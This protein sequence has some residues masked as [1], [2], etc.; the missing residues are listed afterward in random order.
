MKKYLL[1]TTAAGAAL[2]MAAPAN[3]GSYVSI[4]GGYSMSDQEASARIGQASGTFG[5]TS[6]TTGSTDTL[7]THGHIVSYVT[8]GTMPIVT[9]ATGFG[10]THSK[11]S[12]YR[13][14]TYTNGSWKSA[15][16]V[17]F[18]ADSGFVVGAA[19]GKD[20]ATGLRGEIEFS[21]RKND[22][23]VDGTNYFSSEFSGVWYA[24]KYSYERF[25]VTEATVSATISGSAVSNT[26]YFGT[27]P[28]Y[29]PTI[30][31]NPITEAGGT[32][33]GGSYT[34]T[35]VSASGDLSAM[36]IMANVWLDV[37][38]NLGSVHPY[39]GAGIGYAD[40][41]LDVGGVETGDTAVAFQVA[42]GFGWDLPN[43]GH[44]INLEVRRFVV[45]K[46]ELRLDS[47][48][49]PLDY[50]TTDIIVAYRIN[51]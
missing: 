47:W 17:D 51:F 40:V 19:F 27:R 37:D 22:V 23:S 31:E 34:K 2:A 42:A 14:M 41:T 12:F 8:K 44:R 39:V 36:S 7:W 49:I 6:T 45:P 43:S 30:S 50:E 15:T 33:G 11:V 25:H 32:E 1:T 20:I 35:D 9:E 18:E 26:H 38:M 21:Y 5:G 29:T 13:T 46:L 48:D 16:D 3:A 10:I 4:F 24:V 28:T